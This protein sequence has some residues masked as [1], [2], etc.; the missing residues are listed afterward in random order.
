MLPQRTLKSLTRAVGVGIHTGQRVELTLKPA[1]PDTGIV[2]RRIDL[3]QPVEIPARWD[4]VSD[5]RMASTISVG[6]DPGAPRVQTI[7]HFMSACCGLGLD[8]LVV[9]ITADEMPVLDGSSASFVF[10]LRSAGLLEQP[11]PR[12]FLRVKK[13]VR[14]A[15]GEGAGAMWSQLAPH[16]GFTLHFEIDFKHPAVDATGQEV[17]FDLGSGQYARDIARA[18]TFGFTKDVEAMRARGLTLGGAMDNA[19]VIDD[20]K[21]LNAGGLRYDDEFAKHKILDAMGDLYVAGHPMLAAFT[22]F[23]GGHALNNRLLRAL[24]AD[25]EAWDIVQF[26]SAAQAPAGFATLGQPR[27]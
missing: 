20:R 2:F 14:V 6:G 24:M 12:R 3:A 17:D 1:A 21:V 25:R 23:K 7:E 9:D 16:H 4:C 5:T 26:D 13:P 15:Q 18:R 19:I 8:N 10:L 27:L 22:S 11:A